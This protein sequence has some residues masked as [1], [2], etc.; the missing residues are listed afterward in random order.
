MTAWLFFTY[1]VIV[2]VACRR[3]LIIGLIVFLSIQFLIAFLFVFTLESI[4][5][6]W[7]GVD[8]SYRSLS[9]LRCK[10]GILGFLVS[11][12]LKAIEACVLWSLAG[13]WPEND[14]GKKR[15][16][17]IFLAYWVTGSLFVLASY[18]LLS[19]VCMMF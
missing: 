5:T 13:D 16:L 3:P 19:F 2:R 14:S 11:L 9:L 12:L 15:G 7:L 10:V 1:Q 8:D 18:K 17:V 6:N 4:N